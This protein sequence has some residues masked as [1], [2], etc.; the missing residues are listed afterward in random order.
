MKI[1]YI[2]IGLSTFITSSVLGQ[3]GVST[4][5][6][7]KN[8][9]VNGDMR[10]RSLSTTAQSSADK[11]LT[12]DANG[13]VRQLTAYKNTAVG[14]MKYGMQQADHSGWYLLNGRNVSTLPTNAQSNAATIGITTTLDNAQN[15]FIRSN[16]TIGTTGGSATQVLSLA[17]MPLYN[18]TGTT[19]ASGTHSHTFQ[20]QWFHDYDPE[21]IASLGKLNTDAS[22]GTT[23]DR[24]RYTETTIGVTTSVNAW[25]HSHNIT[26]PSGGTATAFSIEPQYLTANLFI[27]L[28][29]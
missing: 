21:N 2:V 27:Y 29:L 10:A 19:N 26:A 22:P 3:T 5:G 24:Q 23:N 25:A 7:T 17:Q 8:L 14:D 11:V 28:G 1:T 9:D 15:R 16:T 13:N 20:D 6:P 18:I 12:V 4:I